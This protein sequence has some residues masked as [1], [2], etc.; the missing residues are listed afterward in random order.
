MAVNEQGKHVVIPGRV[1]TAPARLIYTKQHGVIRSGIVAENYY[2]AGLLEGFVMAQEI[3]NHLDDFHRYYV[4]AA[5]AWEKLTDQKL[6]DIGALV[7]FFKAKAA[8]LEAPAHPL[9]DSLSDVTD[10]LKGIVE[11]YNMRFAEQKQYK[12]AP[13][14]TL[15]DLLLLN[16]YSEL[17]DIG[18]KIQ[19]ERLKIHSTPKTKT[20]RSLGS[21]DVFIL[22]QEL[23]AHRASGSFI[24]LGF[25]TNSAAW[26]DVSLLWEALHWYPYTVTMS[27]FR[28]SITHPNDKTSYSLDE[29]SFSTQGYQFI[30]FPGQ[31][32]STDSVS[33]SLASKQLS[34]V[35]LRQTDFSSLEGAATTTK[36]LFDVSPWMVMAAALHAPNATLSTLIGSWNASLPYLTSTEWKMITVFDQSVS[37]IEVHY[38][39]L[40]HTNLTSHLQKETF[41]L[42]TSSTTRLSGAQFLKHGY[43]IR[44]EKE[45]QMQTSAADTFHHEALARAHAHHTVAEGKLLISTVRPEFDRA[46]HEIGA[47]SGLYYPTRPAT[48][49]F[50]LNSA[51]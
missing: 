13:S 11:G 7:S 42:T 36:P 28:V 48:A 43:D 18:A 25:E 14:I 35:A 17:L 12:V 31:V 46:V 21:T 32:I 19:G 45:T 37:E 34:M 30:G 16:S 47:L 1:Q 6:A 5:S 29:T 39:G 27:F 41:L 2:F 49:F 10:H 8:Q 23:L 33:L 38:D 26:P 24:Q 40:L 20:A 3:S 4:L 51:R 44:I 50:K 22:C 9:K 15:S